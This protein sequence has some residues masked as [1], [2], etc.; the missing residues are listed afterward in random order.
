MEDID[1]TLYAR[2]PKL[3]VPSTVTIALSLI[4]A[5]PKPAPEHVRAAAT[6]VRKDAVAL[7]HARGNAGLATV[8]RDR[9]KSDIRIDT[10]WAG[11][12]DRLESYSRRV[13]GPGTSA[14][15]ATHRSENERAWLKLEEHWTARLAADG[16]L[17]DRYVARYAAIT[18]GGSPG[19][20]S[21]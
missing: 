21:G 10:A 9:R 7:Q 19:C 12:L 14:T 2:P 16:A 17:V 5:M 8:P 20:L 13:S 6:K 3:D 15:D 11:L 1:A 18:T 4:A